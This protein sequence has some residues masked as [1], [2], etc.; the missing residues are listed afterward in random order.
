MIFFNRRRCCSTTRADSR[1]DLRKAMP[2]TH[3]ARARCAGG[4][5]YSVQPAIERTNRERGE[6]IKEPSSDQKQS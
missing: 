3:G 2:I 6:K 1:H 4:T 5:V